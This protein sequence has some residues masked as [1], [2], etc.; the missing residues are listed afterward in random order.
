MSLATVRGPLPRPSTCLPPR[1]ARCLACPGRTDSPEGTDQR[2]LPPCDTSDR[3]SWGRLASP[4]PPTPSST[5]PLL[6]RACE[7][8][9]GRRDSAGTFSPRGGTSSAADGS[10]SLLPTRRH[11]HSLRGL[12][13]TCRSG[14][15]ALPGPLPS[16]GAACADTAQPVRGGLSRGGAPPAAAA[17]KTAWFPICAAAAGVTA[18]CGVISLHSCSPTLELQRR[19]C[20]RCGASRG[21]LSRCCCSDDSRCLAV[22]E[23]R[24]RASKE[25]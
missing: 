8:R 16:V 11:V 7:R 1:A 23:A 3:D 13:R 12:G 2:C 10:R 19:C 21:E 6:R 18:S 5:P 22:P 17:G 9:C 20:C 4:A 14:P 24:V 25:S 15:P